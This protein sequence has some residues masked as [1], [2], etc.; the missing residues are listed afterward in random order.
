MLRPQ[1][2][3]KVHFFS[4]KLTSLDHPR[5]TTKTTSDSESFQKFI[6]SQFFCIDIEITSKVIGGLDTCD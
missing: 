1:R 2:A 3:T 5:Y 6:V 4:E